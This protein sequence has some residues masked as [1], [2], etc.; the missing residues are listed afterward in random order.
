MS[1]KNWLVRGLLFENC[2]CQLVCPAHISFKQH[3][4]NEQCIGYW[5]AHIGEGKFG[6]TVLDGLNAVIVFQSPQRMYDGGWTQVF[7]I[8]DRADF[9][10]QQALEVIL[11]GKAGG[12]WEILAQF[13]D[14]Q[15]ESRLVPIQFEDEGPT[16]RLNI[17]GYLE[18]EVRAI[19]SRNDQGS[20]VLS[21]LFNVIHGNVH[22][23]ARGST[24]C[25]HREIPFVNEQ[26]H[27]VYS[28]FSWEGSLE[29]DA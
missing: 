29:V 10:Q 17:E 14:K 3:C 23:L 28:K 11:S 4:T 20:V 16:K 1:Q 18:A 25:Q 12:P 9:E 8:D 5:A 27:S 24:R 19:R 26:S 2:N 6:E 21:N 7:F 15:L 22:V 13:V